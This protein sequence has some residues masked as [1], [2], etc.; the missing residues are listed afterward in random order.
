M[1][2]HELFSLK[3]K[4]GVVTGAASGIGREIAKMFAELGGEVVISDINYV[5]LIETENEIRQRGNLFVKS[6]IADITKI[7]DV[8]S[9]RDFAIKELGRIDALFIVPAINIRKS[10]EDYSYEE[11]D[12]IL[13]VNLRGYI[14]L[15]KEFLPI[16]KKNETGGS[17]ILFSSIRHITVEPGQFVYSATKAAIVQLARVAAAEY[18]KYNIRVNCIAPGVVDTPL[19]RQIKEDREW[20]R[21][22]TN[23]TALKRWASPTEIASVALFLAM[24]ASSYITGSVIYVDGGWTAIDGRFEPKLSSY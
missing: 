18:G 20:Y 1:N 16:M 15:L 5:E 12:R 22:Y 21:A 3:G 2:Y 10:I 11:I 14:I 7:E 13:N 24:D 8:R 6:R 19:T 9:L 23:K 17:V 4:K